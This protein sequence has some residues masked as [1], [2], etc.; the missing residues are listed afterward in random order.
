MEAVAHAGPNVPSTLEI[1]EV[2]EV[3]DKI[4]KKKNILFATCIFFILFPVC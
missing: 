2:V 3:R 4:D 1:V